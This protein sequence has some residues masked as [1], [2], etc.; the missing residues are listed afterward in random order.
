VPLGGRIVA[1]YYNDFTIF[2]HPDNLGSV[3]GSASGPSGLPCEEILFYPFGEL[4]TGSSGCGTHQVFAQ[5]PDYD[6]EIDEYNTANRHYTPSGRWMS[7]DPGGLKVV[8]MDDPQTWNMYAYVRNDPTTLTDPTGLAS[9]DTTCSGDL[10]SIQY[11]DDAQK[12]ADSDAQNG[13]QN[14]SWWGRIVS[15]LTFSKSANVVNETDK[16][17]SVGL[18]ANTKIAGGS[19]NSAIGNGK[20][21]AGVEVHG[22]KTELNF[23]SNPDGTTGAV[24]GQ[25]TNNYATAEANAH[26]DANGFG[27][28]AEAQVVTF[29]GSLNIGSM[30]VSG[31]VCALCVGAQFSAGSSG[32]SA[33][34]EGGPVGADFSVQFGSTTILS[35]SADAN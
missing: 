17:K 2:D 27:A 12:K 32:V 23:S 14:K 13:A 11:P 20:V 6:P 30:T 15:A 16:D 3:L 35:K 28:K 1:E 9:G 7:P 31:S 25:V 34:Y 21:S 19:V 4:W 5:L 22:V 24:N 26:V 10:C 33:G 8:N 18:V 29:G